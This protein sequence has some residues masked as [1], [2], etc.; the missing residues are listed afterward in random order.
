[1]KIV[2]ILKTKLHYYPPCV[3]QIR[4]INDLGYDIEVLY[5]TS[6]ISAINLL[7]KENICCTK[8]GNIKADSKNLIQKLITYIKFRNAVS[9]QLKKYDENNTVLWFGTAES[10]IPLLGK[11]KGKKYIVS[12]LE[13]L[14][15]SK[16]KLRLLKSIAKNAMATTVC[17]ETRGYI[18]R[19][20]WNLKN[21][22]YVFPNKPYNLP[23]ERYQVPSIDETEKVISN[24]KNKKVI[25]YQGIIQNT[26][27]IS[28]VAKALNELNNSYTLL[29][30]GIDKYN[31]VNKIKEIYKDVI[32]VNYIPAPLHLEITSYAHIGITFYRDDS[33]NKVFCAPNKIYEY[34]AFGIPIIAND[35]PGLKNTV[36][37]FGAAECIKL[38]KDNI[39]K[40]IN[41]IEENYSIYSA[42]A[43]KFFESTDNKDTMK[44]L[45]CEI[46]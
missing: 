33:L 12:F 4:M 42:N 9:N 3:S 45:L 17:E 35:I 41:E 39:I 34:S 5:G 21:L 13:L 20:W 31:S 25:L 23:T 26:E 40:A 19:Y 44:R 29:L 2:Y 22:P 14:D 6:D 24:I 38:N 7:E 32:F 10:V 43:K 37:K 18:M 46:M 1:M 27:E 36:G 30:M 16:L 8:V 15:N 28:E 11:L